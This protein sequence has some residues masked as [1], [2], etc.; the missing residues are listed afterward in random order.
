[1]RSSTCLNGI[2]LATALSFFRTGIVTAAPVPVREGDVCDPNANGQGLGLLQD[3]AF[4]DYARIFFDERNA[5]K[6]FDKYIP[7]E[8]I[9]HV[10][11]APAQ[12]REAAI[13]GLTAL[14]S[15]PDMIWD[16]LTLFTGDGFGLFYY[17]RYISGSEEVNFAVMDKMRFKGTCLVEIWNVSQRIFGNE[18]NP[19]AFF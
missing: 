2:L 8:Y 17:R 15:N 6:A 12:G 18:T 3:A 16:R 13:A 11:A 9:N 14:Q 7:G 1:M 5:K 4:R 10:A 19:I